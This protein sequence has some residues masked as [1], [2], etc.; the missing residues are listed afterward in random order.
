MKA[1]NV[2]ALPRALAISSN[3]IERQCLHVKYQA[4]QY[5]LFVRIF[6]VQ[7]QLHVMLG[8]CTVLY[9]GLLGSETVSI[10]SFDTCAVRY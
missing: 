5:V 3:K 8:F 1:Y 10:G 9:G 4:Q 2:Q 6:L 7:E